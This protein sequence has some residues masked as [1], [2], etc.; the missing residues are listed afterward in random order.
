MK[1]VY[2]ILFLEN[3]WA[4]TGACRDAPLR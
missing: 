4:Y 2:N 1:R 3:L